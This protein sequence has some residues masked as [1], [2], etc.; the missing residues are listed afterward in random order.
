MEISVVGVMGIPSGV[1]QIDTTAK[2][3]FEASQAALSW[4]HPQARDG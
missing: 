2:R 4:G 1:K 3:S